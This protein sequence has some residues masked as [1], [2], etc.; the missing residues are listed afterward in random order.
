MPKETPGPE[1]KN[2]TTS[3]VSSFNELCQDALFAAVDSGGPMRSGAF[4]LPLV[5][6]TILLVLIMKGLSAN[7][8]TDYTPGYGSSHL[9]HTD[10]FSAKMRH[11]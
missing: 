7:T 11:Q 5:T 9:L 2:K 4:N 1:E 3:G 6:M 10:C 8:C